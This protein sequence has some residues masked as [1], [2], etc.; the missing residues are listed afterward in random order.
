MKNALKIEIDSLKEISEKAAVQINY[1]LS[2]HDKLKQH[3][4]RAVPMI[5]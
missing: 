3:Y 5:E 1:V 2:E 4:N